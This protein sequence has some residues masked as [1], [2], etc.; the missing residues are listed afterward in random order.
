MAEGK[1]LKELAELVGGFLKG[2][3]ATL[4]TGVASLEEAKAGDITFLSHQR[5]KR[6]LA[7][8]G[9]SAIVVSPEVAESVEGKNLIV[10]ENPYLAFAKIMSHLKPVTHPP[11]GISPE[12]HIDPSATIG[13]D[14][15]IQAGVFISKGAKVGNRVVLYSGVYI[16]DNAEIGDDTVIYPN[17]SIREESKIGR[18]VI[19]HCN[20]VIGSDGFGY[21]SEGGKHHKI[22]QVG[23]V[24]V[25]DDVEIGACVTIDRATTGSTVIGKG[26][27]IDNLVQIAH[28]VRI[29]ENSI[30]VAQAGV[31]GSAKIGNRVTLAGQVGVAG[32]LEITDDCV[33]GAKSLV[34]SSVKNKG[35]YTG[36]PLLEHKRWLKAQTLVQKLP[37]IKDKLRELEERLNRLEKK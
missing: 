9:A 18:R 17:V 30:V 23:T 33:I 34:S 7:T 3:E 14:V 15:S 12:A 32:H 20:S 2:D 36:Y 1:R 4:I 27:K 5:Y 29:G 37:E 16:G 19:I 13:S 31:A 25:E 28:N 11:A 8:T 26:T 10:V 21:I 6:F 22:P 24:V 35:A